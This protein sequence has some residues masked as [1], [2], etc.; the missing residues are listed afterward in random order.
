MFLLAHTSRL[1]FFILSWLIHVVEPSFLFINVSPTGHFELWGAAGAPAGGAA[2]APAGTVGT[3]GGL[4][5]QYVPAPRHAKII[6]TPKKTATD[7]KLTMHYWRHGKYEC[8]ECDVGPFIYINI[9]F[10]Q[11]FQK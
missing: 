5:I 9:F 11:D 6:I 4:V 10:R 3:L 1:I 2:G 7:Y 8:Y